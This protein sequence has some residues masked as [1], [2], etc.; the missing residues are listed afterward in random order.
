MRETLDAYKLKKA[1]IG[2]P[3]D[4]SIEDLEM[5]VAALETR[6]NE[7]DS[8]IVALKESMNLKKKMN[9]YHLLPYNN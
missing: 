7:K 6:I 2:K 3:S 1:Q 9:R 4:R 5:E 8:K